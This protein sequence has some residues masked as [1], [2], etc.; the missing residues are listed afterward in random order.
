MVTL[1]VPVSTLR[2][3]YRDRLLFPEKGWRLP[4]KWENTGPPE[5]G[6]T[7]YCFGLLL[8]TSGAVVSWCSHTAKKEI[9]MTKEEKILYLFQLSVQT[10]TAYQT[11]AMTSDKNYSTSENPMDDISKLYE[12]FE[13]LLD[14]KFAEAGFK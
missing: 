7:C 3:T 8:T 2:N 11:A 4:D 5:Q 10:H 6:V 13:A 14:K 1:P 12:K 9:K